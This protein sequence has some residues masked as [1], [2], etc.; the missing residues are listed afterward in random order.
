[1]VLA[2]FLEQ[3]LGQSL[4]RPSPPAVIALILGGLDLA[5]QTRTF[6]KR[7]LGASTEQ[8]SEETAVF[9]RESLYDV[10]TIGALA[11]SANFLYNNGMRSFSWALVVAPLL[12]IV[13]TIGLCIYELKR[14]RE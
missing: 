13:I 2:D 12:I 8:E 9:A 14:I 7:P 1:M 11:I 4:M 5:H 6:A 10:L 3:P